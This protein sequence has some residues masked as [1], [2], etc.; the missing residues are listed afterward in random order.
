MKHE[1]DPQF[2]VCRL[3]GQTAM[4]YMEHQ[5]ECNGSPNGV[6]GIIN[7]VKLKHAGVDV[8]AVREA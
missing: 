5:K 8:P 3:C 6:D 1:F 2:A 7:L 4:K